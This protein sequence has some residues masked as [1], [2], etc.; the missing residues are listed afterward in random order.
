MSAWII[1]G[2]ERKHAP[3]E[4]QEHLNA[5]GGMNRFG[6]PNFR[7]VWGET[8]IDVVQGVD[9]N[10]KKG[11]HVI[12]KHGGIPAWFIEVWKPPECFGTPEFW[13]AY[14]WDW[15]VDRPTLGDYP[16][17]G[18]YMPAPFNLY[19][20]KIE[21]RVLRFDAMPLNHYIL[22]LLIPNVM[23]AADETFTQRKAAIH[24][25]MQAEKQE[26]AKKSMDAYLAA[27]P[28]F[29]GV[30]GTY[31]SNREAW[32]ARIAEKQAGMNVSRD[33]IVKRLGLG[34]RQIRKVIP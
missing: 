2:H 33:D 25:R 26:A 7:I 31:E 18:M 14:T 9:A 22:D 21:N 3:R 15:E 30:A 27:A 5:I 19:V 8:P 29:G 11:A 13:Y 6:E 17:R 24:N 10:G 34:H 16:W 23:K 32:A 20:K 4:Y 1:P 12:L 28:A